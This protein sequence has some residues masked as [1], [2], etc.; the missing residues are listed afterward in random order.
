[1]RDIL[2]KPLAE[3]VIVI[4]GASSGIG[5]ATARAAAER[6]ARLVL[7]ARNAEALATI[8]AELNNA[9]HHAIHVVA[10]VSRREDVQRIA[11]VARDR[12]GGF[13]TWI[14]NAG[15]SIWG[16]LEDVSEADH[17]HL[18]DINF[19]GAVNGSL[20]A[21]E[22]L[23]GNGGAIINVGSAASD[24]ALPLQGMYSAS[25]HALKGFTDALRMELAERHVPVS[26]TLIK[27]AG[28]DTPFPQNARNYT[29]REPK[30]PPPVYRP[31]EVARAILYAAEH[32]VRDLYVGATSRLMGLMNQHVPRVMDWFGTRIGIHQQLRDEPPRDPEGALHK[33]GAGGRVQGDHSG[34]VMQRS[35]YIRAA[36]NP[37]TTR[38]V[39]T[40]I[41]VAALGWWVGRRLLNRGRHS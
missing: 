13:D 40:A 9:G 7:A 30:L 31:E 8:A 2:L 3:Q 28:I 27:P 25:K 19:W 36:M 11:D 1:M 20:I 16:H 26:L 24:I 38:S 5:L 23:K 15:L 12:F 4:T 37:Q 18:F 21:L 14:N 32:P 33:P 22:H 10:D 34:R 41:G 39:M 6:D 35:L 29:G 17:R